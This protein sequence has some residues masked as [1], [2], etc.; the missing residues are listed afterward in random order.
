MIT[1]TSPAALLPQQAAQRREGAGTAPPAQRPRARGR[2]S[3][4]RRRLLYT[5]LGVAALALV[6]AACARVPGPR[7]ARRP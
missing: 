7:G 6:E 1:E 3:R 4:A 2:W 5:L